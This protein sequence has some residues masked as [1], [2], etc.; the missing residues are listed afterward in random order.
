MVGILNILGIITWIISNILFLVFS[1]QVFRYSGTPNWKVNLPKYKF[2]LLLGLDFILFLLLK[3]SYLLDTQSNS[4]GFYYNSLYAY[5][6]GILPILTILE[7]VVKL[8][9]KSIYSD[10]LVILTS[11]VFDYS[12]FCLLSRIK[13]IL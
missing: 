6:K 5:P 12:F 3:W 10:F 7:K 9:E 2:V 4:F 13:K 11:W 1:I 8:N